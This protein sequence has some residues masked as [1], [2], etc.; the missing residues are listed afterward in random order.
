MSG[1]MT[2][3]MKN[4]MKPL[5]LIGAMT[6]AFT[7]V[8]SNNALATTKDEAS[9]LAYEEILSRNESNDSITPE[10]TELLGERID[11][12]SGTVSFSQTDVSLAGNNALSVALTRVHK[13]R[14]YTNYNRSDFYDWAL[15]IPYIQS[16]ALQGSYMT[17]PWG[18][19]NT[20]DGQRL[21]PKE[22][23]GELEQETTFLD[24]YPYPGVDYYNGDTINIPGQLNEK[25]L[26]KDTAGGFSKRTKSNWV[27]KCHDNKDENGDVDNTG[28][29]FEVYSP[30]GVVYTFAHR[31]N[32]FDGVVISRSDIGIPQQQSDIAGPDLPDSPPSEKKIIKKNKTLTNEDS[33]GTVLNAI[34]YISASKMQLFMFVT[35]VK[36][37]FG[38]TVTYNYDDTTGLLTSIS[39]SDGRLITIERLNGKK[40]I[41]KVIAN[42]RTWT[43]GYDA[44][45]ANLKTVTLP[46]NRF[47]S[48]DLD[49]LADTA[50]HQLQQSCLASSSY[51]TIEGSITHPNGV[52]GT[53]VARKTVHGNSNVKGRVLEPGGGI[54]IIYFTQRCNQMMSL[55][56][57]TLS[58]KDIDNM[59]W[60]YEYSQNLG[61]YSTYEDTT[62]ADEVGTPEASVSEDTHGLATT[63]STGLNRL[64]HKSTTVTTPD[65]AKTTYYH[66]RDFRSALDG[67][68][69]ATE[70]FDT[71]ATLLKTT[72][73]Q[74]TPQSG[75]YGSSSLSYS[76]V[77]PM[78]IRLELTKSTTK[79]HYAGGAVDEYYTQNSDFNIYGAARKV[80]EYNN[81]NSSN[82]YTQYSF[83][84]DITQWILNQPTTTAISNT[85]SN[86]T[87]VSENTYYAKDHATYPFLP[88]EEKS[89]GQW[90]KRYVAYHT[91]GAA[92]LS[93]IGTPSAQECHGNISKIEFNAPLVDASGN[94][95]TTNRYV[96]YNSYK[97]GRPQS[98]TVPTR[99]STTG[100]MSVN[101]EVDNNGW[102]NWATDFDGNK[103]SFG[104][105]GLGRRT[106]VN[107]TNAEVADTV[108]EYT[109]SG[110]APNNQLK[111]TIRRC[112]LDSATKKCQA[113]TELL[114]S[115]STL[116]ALLRPVL[117]QTTDVKNAINV[118]Q[119]STFNAYNKPVFQSYS[120]STA[121]E[122]SGNISHY[123]GL[124]RAKRQTYQQN[125]VETTAHGTLD[126]YYLS[127]NRMEVSDFNSHTTTTTYQAYGAP[128]YEQATSIV[129]PEGVTTAILYNKFGNQTTITQSGANSVSHT[130]YMAY[131]SKQ[132]LCKVKRG[133]VGQTV[134]DYKTSGELNWMAQGTTG[135]SATN[136]INTTTAAEKVSFTY[137]NGGAK[138]TISYG[139][140]T[141]TV[142]YTLNN[143]GDLT[144]LVAGA[145]TQS[146]DY[147]TARQLD[148]ETLQVD[149]KSLVL[150]YDY[151]SLGHLSNLTYPDSVVGKVAFSPNAFGQARQ[152][153]GTSGMVYAQ[154]GLYHPTGALTSLN[155]GN[156]VTHTT[157]L[158]TLNQP[159]NIVDAKGAITP[160][161]LSYEYDNQSNITKLTDNINSA[162]SLT[163]LTYDGLDRLTSTTGGSGIGSSELK[164]DALGNITEYSSKGSKLTYAYDRTLN[165]LTGV[166]DSIGSKNYN[167]IGG[168]DAR[169]N[170]TYNGN[171]SFDYNLANQMFESEGNTY[172]Y[173][174]FNRRVKTTD[175]KGTKY[176]MY[177]QAGKL[178]YRETQDGPISYI[179]MGSK[180]VAKDGY[181]PPA[182]SGDMHYKSFGESIETPVDAV[183][184]TG[185]KFDT[186]LGLSYMQARY[187]DPV[188]GRFM[189]NDPVGFSNI[190]NF[191]RYTYANNNPYKYIDP[192]GQAAFLAWFL[193]PPGIA[194]LKTAAEIV[195]VGY[196]ATVAVV[197]GTETVNAYKES[198]GTRTLEEL[199]T[200]HDPDHPQNDPEIGE[201]SDEELTN[202]INNPKEGDK[203]RVKGNVVLDG[204]TRIN[205]A[206]SR[207]FDGS[208]EI[209]VFEEPVP[210]YDDDDPLGPY[211]EYN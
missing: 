72:I 10:T 144:S 147:T 209:P 174:G 171:R 127:G 125:G 191:N 204:N 93:D 172:L 61:Y 114:T 87:T 68:L 5:N 80:H 194:A 35:Q 58:G 123:D 187:Y 112:T 86:Y 173:D 177:S 74:Y 65:G 161:N 211:G 189:S 76:N 45:T 205:E 199:E 121:S 25:L 57:K 85:D 185:H 47:W 110:V 156:G 115:T 20:S 62:P 79:L 36:D 143:N 135:G 60:N 83:D 124:Q 28:E 88:L 53:F 75:S 104:Y 46:D 94:A 148:I 1:L 13:S 152:A 49:A 51:G 73:N 142:N 178:L 113:G 69:V 67:S 128:S 118:Y 119:N 90:H 197:V 163:A 3:T 54:P 165:R 132:R 140:G 195:V 168:Y 198:E 27:I 196:V 84:H 37:R 184:Y 29:Y 16:T 210:V 81:F 8:S 200:I 159:I 107:P 111:Q 175:S 95:S 71:D 131:D 7:A 63:G 136:C 130:Q 55:I 151:N 78:E 105:D 40:R 106:S 155:Y 96:S 66:N 181:N 52:T 188:I 157:T 153:I 146:Y 190:H 38:N 44:T 12:N 50:H 133:D 19:R 193:T 138:R 70:Y 108:I 2:K 17:G 103:V 99:Y 192:N 141:S 182:K 170:V 48:Y 117:T 102:V 39:A 4:K 154:A 167:F 126:T 22:C 180:L 31:V 34:Q 176:S 109:D 14:A 139:D 164:Y 145:V 201:L 183:G 129:S 186:D 203:V 101:T 169:G 41:D 158:N 6:L 91:Q 162:Y 77:K 15:D 56:K 116:D 122:N 208:T 33:D 92:C 160:M 134:Y 9:P 26:T 18:W 100:T 137:D 98:V 206:K 43:Y 21:T 23:S 24:G 150:N 120:S 202:A 32:T 11:L 42:G 149:G 82:R 166:S 30:Q 59:V 97:R 64:D 179:F 89:F 207:G